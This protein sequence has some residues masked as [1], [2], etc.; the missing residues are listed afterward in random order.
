MPPFNM[1]DPSFRRAVVSQYVDKLNPGKIRVR[2]NTDDDL[3]STVDDDDDS[4]EDYK[5][6]LV[7][8]L[9][10]NTPSRATTLSVRSADK[11]S[12]VPTASITAQ[13][14]A[15]FNDPTPPTQLRSRSPVLQTHQY[16]G[17]NQ[18]AD[19]APL[20]SLVRHN[21]LRQSMPEPKPV[22]QAGNPFN[23]VAKVYGANEGSEDER[24]PDYESRGQPQTLKR[25]YD[26]IDHD[27]K[28]LEN[29]KF[30]DLEATPFL[31][32]PR[33][34]ALEPPVDHNGAP[35]PLTT[36]LTNLT[37]LQPTDQTSL[38]RSLDDDE[39]EQVGQWFV[40]TFQGDLKKLMEIR[41]ERRKL[42]LKYE[43]EV[44]KRETTVKAKASDFEMELA[45]LRTGGGNLIKGLSVQQVGG[46]PKG[47][48]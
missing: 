40:Q 33:A 28:Q 43:M 16:E 1:N 7:D 29:M 42:A 5:D 17:I 6:V 23:D 27:G 3:G 15:R 20:S 12:R 46:T 8:R 41:I 13:K 18:Q 36:R 4:D 38:F 22:Q 14:K 45:D 26:E 44:K 19:P 32:D 21:D 39:N 30:S 9:Q 25:A 37:K 11:T 35:M 2:N 47:K 34:A 24:V 10:K 31:T 48:A